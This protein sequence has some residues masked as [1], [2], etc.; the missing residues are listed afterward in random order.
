MEQT[1]ITVTK[2]M[3]PSI[4]ADSIRR[5]KLYVKL[6]KM[7]NFPLTFVIAGAGYGKSTSLA[8]YVNDSHFSVCWYTVSSRDQDLNP[9]ITYLIYAIKR[10][11]PS[12]GKMILSK[13]TGGSVYKNAYDIGQIAALFVNDLIKIPS[14][15]TLI[16]D[17]FHHVM[18]VES[19]QEFLQQVMEYCPHHFHL[20]ISSRIK[21]KWGFMKRLRVE[22]SL[23]EINQDELI[24][25][26]DEVELLLTDYYGLDISLAEIDEIYQLTEGWMLALGI[27][28]LDLQKKDSFHRSFER[29]QLTLDDL[30][31]YI[32]LEVISKQPKPFQI[33]L[34]QTCILT[35]LSE[36][37]CNEILSISDSELIL[38]S[39][40]ESH[41]FLVS[42]GLN[43]FRYHGLIK[44]LLEKQLNRESPVKY[45]E[46]HKKAA[47]F[48]EKQEQVDLMF[49]HLFKSKRYQTMIERLEKY[50]LQLLGEGKS[51]MLSETLSHIPNELKNQFAWIWFFSGEVFRIRSE[52][53]RAEEAYEKAIEISSLNHEK[54]LLSLSYEGKAMI[55]LDTTQPAKA[56]RYLQLAIETREHIKNV[57]D[58]EFIELYYLLAENQINIGKPLKAKK[59]LEQAQKKNIMMDQLNL[60][61]RLLLRT[62]SLQ[63][64]LDLLMLQEAKYEKH[65]PNHLSHRESSL[66]L[67]L[68]QGFLGDGDKSKHFAQKAIQHG[69]SIQSSYVEACGWIRLGHAVQIAGYGPS[70]IVI[71]CYDTALKLME[72]MN[73]ARGKAEPY[74]G[75]CL[76]WGT[77]VQGLEKSMHYGQ[78]A[79]TETEQVQDVWL[80]SLIKLSMAKSAIFHRQYR[81]AKGLL[82]GACQMSKDCQDYYGQM[83][84]TFWKTIIASKE[85]EKNDFV[86]YCS[87][88]LEFVQQSSFQFFYSRKTLFGP[89]DMEQMIPILLEAQNSGIHTGFVQQALYELGYK[90]VK[91]H[92]GY[93]LKVQTFGSFRVFAGEEEIKEWHR[94]KAKELFEFFITNP[95]H[96]FLKQE[97]IQM[98]WPNIDEATASRDFKVVIN[99]LNNTL[100]P[101]RKARTEPFFIKRA[102]NYYGLNKQAP[103]VL[104]YEEFEY[105]IASGLDSNQMERAKESLERA[106][107]LYKGEFLADHKLDDWSNSKRDRL[108]L[109]FLRGAEKIAQAYIALKDVNKAI[110]WC[111]RI[112]DYEETWEEAYRLLMY[113]FYRTNNRSQ[114]I[115]IYHKCKDML[116][117][118]LAVEPLPSTEKMYRMIVDPIEIEWIGPE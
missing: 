49:F 106:L 63:E 89:Q 57:N 14:V 94:A 95:Q 100:E 50:G 60:N 65:K 53:E 72:N 15:I 104:D 92:P 88:W 69:I 91:L 3:P 75:L 80:S 116:K 6:S 41:L 115:K 27:I 64:A 30:F 114:S 42:I 83:I 77:Q 105:W 38:Q 13:L 35:E 17:D 48:Y 2:I 39:L 28:G 67:S 102:G 23:L 12:F 109:L 99:S 66:L 59:W 76:Y 98:L 82:A 47:D 55:Y 51:T 85:K 54:N 107:L 37:V 93:T 44:E 4:K 29:T 26:K 52:I 111:D 90:D 56:E 87:E 8:L 34:E 20:V 62:G 101:N 110:Y 36:A 33:F 68:V 7:N 11:H 97:I 117:K 81:L 112:L 70:E 24:L 86:M 74:M 31:Q 19:I 5:S 22:G 18:N 108:K 43:E 40:F 10:E 73:V 58:Q 61:A 25:S 46:L 32:A 1:H 45:M 113:C 78:L 96:M 79:L 71:E 103:I 84:T 9:F 118:E 16:I 21:P